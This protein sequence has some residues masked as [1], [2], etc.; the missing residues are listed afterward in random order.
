MPP[1]IRQLHRPGQSAL[2]AFYNKV[3]VFMVPSHFEGWGLPAC[4]AM[5]CG[6]ALVT[7]DNGGSQ[8]YAIAGETA[9]VVPPK[10][11]RL[12]AAAVNR[13][14][15]DATLR[16]ALA[17]RGHAFIQR[18]R[19]EHSIDSLERVLQGGIITRQH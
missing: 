12:L 13:L 19:W 5:A 4:E 1:W 6:A 3:S 14:F 11:P 17:E 10:E 15:Q 7:T 8:D 16:N 18:F 2:R 9:L